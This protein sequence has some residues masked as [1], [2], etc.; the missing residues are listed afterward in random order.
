MPVLPE[1]GVG[2]LVLQFGFQQPRLDLIVND[3]L[4]ARGREGGESRINHRAQNCFQGEQREG[5]EAFSPCLFA[6]FITI[7][8]PGVICMKMSFRHCC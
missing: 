2:D 3:H 5:L 1:Q 4:C 6:G 8:K 7:S